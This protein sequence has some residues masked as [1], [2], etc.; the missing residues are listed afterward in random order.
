VKPYA[1]Y[2]PASDVVILALSENW[3]LAR[4]LRNGIEPDGYQVTRRDMV[5]S[6]QTNKYLT[7]RKQNLVV[8]GAWPQVLK[9]PK[10]DLQSATTILSSIQKLGLFSIVLRETEEEWNSTHCRIESVSVETATLS[11][12]DGAGQWE[13]RPQIVDIADITHVRFGSS[14]LAFY[15][16]HLEKKKKT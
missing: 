6:L 10:I 11:G 9:K 13:R 14:Y 4:L 1:A 15:Q 7:F 8:Q 16:R 5:R 2:D 12:F 3:F